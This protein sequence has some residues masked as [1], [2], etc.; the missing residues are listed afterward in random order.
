[1]NVYRG[2]AGGMSD[3]Y[4]VKARVRM[5]GFWKRE[6]EKVTAKRVVRV[7]E[8]EK[9]KVREAFVILIA[10]EWD[11]IRNTRVLSV[12]EWEMFKSTVMT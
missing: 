11:R 2:A 8:L 10:N 5:K 7:S 6:R 1:M 9:E 3:Q 4:L 12:E